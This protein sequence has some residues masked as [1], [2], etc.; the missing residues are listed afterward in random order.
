VS[1]F[2]C[3]R[4]VE[5]DLQTRREWLSSAL[6]VN[7]VHDANVSFAVDVLRSNSMAWPSFPLE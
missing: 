3:T 2:S 6:V 5:G 1:R 4:W 7:H